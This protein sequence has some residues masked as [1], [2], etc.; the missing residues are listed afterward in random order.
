M[1]LSHKLKADIEAHA[2]ACYPE[3]C[4][5]VIVNGVYI[6]CKNDSK[7]PTES[8]II[9][10]LDK[11]RA[12]DI[13]N[14]EAYVHS[15]PDAT[16]FPSDYDRIKIELS[17]KPWVICS[18]PNPEFSV[19]EPCGYVA[20]LVGRNFHHGWQDCYSL[21]RDFYSREL[22]IDIPDFERQ[23][24]WWE[25]SSNPSLYTDNFEKA[26][27]QKVND[28]KYGDVLLFSIRSS[29]SNHASIYLDNEPNLKSEQS[30]PCVGSPLMLHH[31]YGRKSNRELISQFWQ[32]RCT[33]ILRHRSLINA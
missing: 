25:D 22:E 33:H 32:S 15:H 16:H 28:Y 2:K 4:C 24:L 3:E 1:K 13:G 20:P 7:N 17:G 6:K 12:E 18:Y 29:H 26:G 5:G 19:N 14:I 8:F 30:A 23:D 27:F 10:Q 31:L 11:D 9:N 21:I